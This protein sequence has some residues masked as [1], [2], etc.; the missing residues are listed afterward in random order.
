MR[1]DIDR[2][3]VRVDEFRQRSWGRRSALALLRGRMPSLGVLLRAPTRDVLRETGAVSVGEVSEH[4]V[5]L[6]APRR[7]SMGDG[8]LDTLR[9]HVRAGRRQRAREGPP[10]RARARPRPIG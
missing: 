1:A 10:R 3:F 7:T 8:A 4:G 5:G 6:P 2:S 9:L